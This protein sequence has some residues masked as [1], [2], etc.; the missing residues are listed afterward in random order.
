MKTIKK[1]EREWNRCSRNIR[2]M[3]ITWW[4]FSLRRNQWNSLVIARFK[5]K[6]YPHTHTHM[7]SRAEPHQ[8]KRCILLIQFNPMMTCCLLSWSNVDD[9]Q[10]S[11]L[12]LSMSSY[13]VRECTFIL[14]PFDSIRCSQLIE[15][16]LD[17]NRPLAIAQTKYLPCALAYTHNGAKN[18]MK[19]TKRK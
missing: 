5:C 10:I 12:Y 13:I 11:V 7:S 15:N 2:A 1:K 6:A 19:L 9:K 16:I 8:T 18:K 3:S 17:W 14:F 4:L